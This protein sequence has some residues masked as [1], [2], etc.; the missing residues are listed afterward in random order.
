MKLNQKQM[1][2]DNIY[3]RAGINNGRSK[4]TEAQVVVIRARYKKGGVTQAYLAKHF[5]VSQ[6]TIHRIV[7][8][9]LWKR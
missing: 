3:S 4:L 8:N 1:L 7:S 5:G 9:L 6:Q 2:T